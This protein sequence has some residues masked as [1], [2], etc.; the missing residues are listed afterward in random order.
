MDSF[1]FPPK[2]RPFLLR[3][4]EAQ[5][6]GQLHTPHLLDSLYHTYFYWKANIHSSVPTLLKHVF[7][8]MNGS[9]TKLRQFC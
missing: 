9:I 7:H 8:I 4:S 1:S 2:N 5:Y 6:I 3:H